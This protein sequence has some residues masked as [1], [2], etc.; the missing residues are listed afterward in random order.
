MAVEGPALVEAGEQQHLLDEHA[1]ALGLALDAR[2]RFGQVVGPGGRAPPEEL[3]V[4]AD[5][6]QRRAQLVGGV[7]DEASQAVLRRLAFGKRALDARQHG[8]EGCAEAADFGAV[9]GGGHAPAQLAA[10]DGL[11]GGAHPGQGTHGDAH[12]PQ[13]E[14]GHGQGDADRHQQLDVAEVDEGASDVAQRE[15]DDQRLARGADGGDPH[16]ERRPARFGG[17]NR[18]RL[19]RGAGPGVGVGRELRQVRRQPR[20]VGPL[21]RRA[22]DDAPEH[23]AVF[24]AHLQ[25]R[26]RAGDGVEGGHSPDGVGVAGAE[27]LRLDPAVQEVELLV[28][29]LQQ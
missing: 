16:A 6:R 25:E 7:G 13:A 26:R 9:V 12:Q 15:G 5:R 28:D 17:V 27:Q 18:E 14:A 4:A 2:H 19:A 29:A 20:R 23:R 21:V 22:D 8:V 24:V 3:G 11:G 10:G 1:H